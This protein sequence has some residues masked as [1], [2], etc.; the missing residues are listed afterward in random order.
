MVFLYRGY[1]KESNKF[2]ILLELLKTKE[3]FWIA[4]CVTLTFYKF[5]DFNIFDEIILVFSQFLWD[6]EINVSILQ[7]AERLSV[8]L[9]YLSIKSIFI[10]VRITFLTLFPI[11]I[12]FLYSFIHIESAVKFSYENIQLQKFENYKFSM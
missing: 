10:W 11:F 2:T 4:F 3:I 9:R 1:Y 12:I 5:H 8:L 7:F 6:S